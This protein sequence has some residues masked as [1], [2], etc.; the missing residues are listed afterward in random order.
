MFLLY[1]AKLGIP[2]WV[3]KVLEALLLVLL[4]LGSYYGVY[5]WGADIADHKWEAKIASYEQQL[6]A[7]EAESKALLGAMANGHA[8]MVDGLTAKLKAAQDATQKVKVVIQEVPKYVSVKADSECV[9][10]SGFTWLWDLSL[11]AEYAGLPL[12]KPDNVD[13][14]TGIK[15]STVAST[16]AE[17]NAECVERGAVID[18]WQS[19]Y[20][21]TK[22]SW[23]ATAAKL[24]K[25]PPIPK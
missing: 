16:A 1:L 14:E 4:I 11:G 12:S 8:I 13:Q 5:I 9:I 15:I 25:P 10:T 17:N 3:A 21:D 23:D 24:P 19:W 6:K 18:A 22:K 20:T 7:Q 2:D